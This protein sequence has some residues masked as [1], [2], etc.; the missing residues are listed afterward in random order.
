MGKGKLY[1]HNNHKKSIFGDFTIDKLYNFHTNS[2]D[3]R[4]IGVFDNN[5]RLLYFDINEYK[6]W[7]YL[8]FDKEYRRIKLNKLKNGIS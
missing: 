5:N 3:K 2:D 6:K 4:Y 8:A 7:F 1:C